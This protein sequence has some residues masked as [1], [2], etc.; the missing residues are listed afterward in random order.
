MFE[1]ESELT[2]YFSSKKDSAVK[3]V[4]DIKKSTNIAERFTFSCQES[5]SDTKLIW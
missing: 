3:E 5:K 4:I 2:T 1:A